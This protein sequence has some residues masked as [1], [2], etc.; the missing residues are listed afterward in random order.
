[1]ASLTPAL[2]AKAI[3]AQESMSPEQWLAHGDVLFA[4]QRVMFLEIVSFGRDGVEEPQ[5]RGMVD[6]L[7]VLQRVAESL[8]A[9]IASP[10][11]MPEFS[12]AVER[13]VLWFKTL[14]SDNLS[15]MTPMIDAWFA[16]MEKKGEPLIWAM[17]M[18][19]LQEKRIIEA[20]LAS[21]MVITLHAVADVFSARCR[22]LRAG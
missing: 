21:G 22:R 4:K 17:L 6:F 18:N 16:G 15:E 13:A 5:L 8:S 14:D 10:V 7:A 20:P 2:V 12:A 11:E 9:K 1:M 3:R 19:L